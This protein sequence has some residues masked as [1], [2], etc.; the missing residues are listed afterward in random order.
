MN[1]IFN[2][3]RIFSFIA[4]AAL[5]LTSCEK[6]DDSNPTLH[7]PETFQLNTPAEAANTYDLANATTITLTC[8]QPDYGGFPLA[9]SYY[10]QVSVN[11]DMSGYTEMST[12]Y[13]T[14]KMNLNTSELAAMLTSMEVEGGKIEA[15]F[16]MD[17]PVYI[18]LRANVAD[19]DC[20]SNTIELK[21]VHLLYSLPPV[22][23]PDNL[24][25]VG[26]FC[27][28]D[29][30]KCVEMVPVNGSPEVFWHMVYIDG[31]GVKFNMEKDWTPS[32]KG[33]EGINIGG[34]LAGDIIN[35]GGN[36]ASSNPGWYL[37]VVTTSVSGQ[38]IIY[39]VEF[40]K[41]EAWL[42]GT[43]LADTK[44]E[45]ESPA[46]L[47]QAPATADGDFVSPAFLG[48]CPGGDGD[49]VR[50]YVKI[51][52]ND[53]WRAEF[54]VFDGK[55]EYRGT[56]GDQARVACSVGQRLYLNFS[57]DTGEIK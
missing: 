54:M 9:V 30:K 26:K 49:G 43:C 27:D 13:T 53:W 36:I 25:L 33:Y 20:L 55:I 16:P 19:T 15:D 32:A 29:W 47:I 40:N 10:V 48:A 56:G 31:D 4:I 39:N 23:P 50:A 37:M 14:A 17:I 51:G 34:E 28:W 44:W 6:D 35:S 7:V 52:A 42:I 21:S 8:Q 12:S 24:Y 11:P 3:G 1:K 5:A 2:I 38:D 41:P 18:R 22:T 57:T 46:G 45:T